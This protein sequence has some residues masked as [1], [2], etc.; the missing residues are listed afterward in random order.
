[1]IERILL[2]V[3]DT[4]GVTSSAA[5]T[6]KLARKLSSRVFAACVLTARPGQNGPSPDIEERAWELL[7]GIEDDA[8]GENVRISLLLEQ[9]DQLQRL[10]DLCSSYEIDLV[11]AS[12]DSRLSASD[13]VKHN[14]R[15]T[16]FVK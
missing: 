14:T 2:F 9:G 10:R 12:A 15:P 8:F 16:L 1:M 13:L 5:W 4:P 11:V 3:E 6:L 7:Y